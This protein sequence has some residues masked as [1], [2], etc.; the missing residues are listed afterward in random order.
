M[1]KVKLK[2]GKEKVISD[3]TIEI[4][5]KSE[6]IPDC[7]IE[8]NIIDWSPKI[9]V[10]TI[11]R[12]PAFEVGAPIL[13]DDVNPATIDYKILTIEVPFPIFMGVTLKTYDGLYTFIIDEVTRAAPPLV[14]IEETIRIRNV[15]TGTWFIITRKV[16]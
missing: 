4:N 5:V 2:A 8:R 14:G 15:E 6:A 7:R 16:G 13:V 1:I 10:D 11:F 3:P 12:L 9:T